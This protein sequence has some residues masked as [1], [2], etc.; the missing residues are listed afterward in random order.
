MNN[1]Y[2]QR[3]FHFFAIYGASTNWRQN[4]PG[5]RGASLKKN[6]CSAFCIVM[7]AVP[8]RNYFFL[9]PLLLLFRA[10]WLCTL[11]FF[12][13][14]SPSVNLHL[15][16]KTLSP[17]M[18]FA[19]EQRP[20]LKDSDPSLSFSEVQ[21]QLAVLWGQLSDDQKQVQTGGNGKK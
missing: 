17:F 13:F 7:A 15:K 19:N 10:S 16:G 20:K 14:L 1:L 2:F 8:G 18:V 11:L 21:K 6:T 12:S 3:V 9:L 4:G 5:R